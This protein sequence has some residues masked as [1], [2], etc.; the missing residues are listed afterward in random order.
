MI[1][2][3]IFTCYHY[4]FLDGFFANLTQATSL[5]ICVFAWMKLISWQNVSNSY[6]RTIILLLLIWHVYIIFH[7]FIFSYSQLKE[8]LFENYRS[9]QYI[10]PLVVFIPVINPCFLYKLFRY[11]YILGVIFLISFP[12]LFL[13]LTSNQEFSEQYVWV[14][15]SGCGFILLTSFY[16]PKKKIVVSLIVVV[17]SIVLM[18]IMARRNLILTYTGFLFASFCIFLFINKNISI[19]KKAIFTILSIFLL[20]LS[21]QMFVS[22]QSGAFSMITERA[23]ENTRETVFFYYF[24]DMTSSTEDWLTGRGLNGTYYCPN[25]DA[26]WIGEEAAL[27]VDRDLDYRMFIEC[28]YLQLILN[29]GIIYLVLYLLVLIPAFIK[30]LFYSNNIFSK[31]CAILVFL[32]LIDMFPFGLPSF[33]L[34]YFLVWICV[35]ICYSKEIRSMKEDDM[36]NYLS[37]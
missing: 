27:Y 15:A 32:W 7:G 2:Y 30:G 22:N 23:T 26:E 4:P 18:A 34:R 3:M 36:K 9:L 29:G 20:V 21:Y 35:A 11:S 13:F 24:L 16:Q 25:I 37:F 8:Y 19:I 17:L 12:F 33:S 31:S 5:F 10:V 1:I 6:F 28:G 14:L